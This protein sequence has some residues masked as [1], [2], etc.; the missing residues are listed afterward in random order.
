MILDGCRLNPGDASMPYMACNLKSYRLASSGIPCLSPNVV[1]ASAG[2]SWAP[3]HNR[4][5]CSKGVSVYL[6]RVIYHPSLSLI[7]IYVEYYLYPI[8][9]D[10][11]PV[12][13]CA[14]CC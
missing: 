13:S 10:I 12:G 14:L 9:F 3:H 5:S 2:S 8:Y 6:L 11:K 7:N 1:L 4:I